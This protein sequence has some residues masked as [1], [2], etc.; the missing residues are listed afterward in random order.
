[1]FDVH[2]HFAQGRDP[3]VNPLLKWPLGPLSCFDHLAHMTA[4]D[5]SSHMMGQVWTE[6]LLTYGQISFCDSHVSSH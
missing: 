2:T 5:I 1:M 3:S 6:N 4:Y